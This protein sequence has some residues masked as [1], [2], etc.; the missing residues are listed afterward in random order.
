MAFVLDCSVTMAW[1][2]ADEANARTNALRDSLLDNPAVVPTLWA[3]EVANAI[4]SATKRGRLDRNDWSTIRGHLEALPIEVE[5]LTATDT[6][7]G[8]CR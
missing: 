6:W 2:F 4:L 3:I 1:L 5:A 7:S 8:S